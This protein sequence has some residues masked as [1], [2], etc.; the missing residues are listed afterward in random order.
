MILKFD[1]FV[2]AAEEVEK[3]IS[4]PDNIDLTSELKKAG[5]NIPKD[6]KK[7]FY[8]HMN[9]LFLNILLNRLDELGKNAEQRSIEARKIIVTIIN[10]L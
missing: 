3:I 4:L 6:A 5:E 2:K 1:Q 8:R 9:S 7:E 10:E